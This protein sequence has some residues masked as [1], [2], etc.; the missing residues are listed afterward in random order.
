MSFIDLAIKDKNIDVIECA[1]EHDRWEEILSLNSL[2]YKTP[3]IGIIQTSSYLTNLVMDRCVTKKYFKNEPE[4]FLV[5]FNFKYLNW[6]QEAI[7]ETGKIIFT[8]MVPLT[9]GH[10]YLILNFIYMI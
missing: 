9:V 2:T 4:N 10:I 6:D 1:L 5:H 3:F 8:P 7:T